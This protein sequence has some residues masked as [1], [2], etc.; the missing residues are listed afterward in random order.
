MV[1][2]ALLVL[3]RIIVLSVAALVMV[4]SMT[5][6]IVDV[7]NIVVAI[8]LIWVLEW[9]TV[10]STVLADVTVTLCRVSND[11]SLLDYS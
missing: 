1:S 11:R 8:V 5:E 4:D 2:R 7:S 9:V 10:F 6:L 3:G